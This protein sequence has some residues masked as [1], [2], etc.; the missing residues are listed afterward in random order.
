MG[1][2]R[3]RATKSFLHVRDKDDIIKTIGSLRRKDRESLLSFSEII[4]KLAEEAYTPTELDTHIVQGTLINAFIA[5][6]NHNKISEKLTRK[7]QLP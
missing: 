4:F 1:L 5:G 3:G 7:N 2:I 6:L